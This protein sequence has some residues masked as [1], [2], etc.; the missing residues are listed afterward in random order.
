MYGNAILCSRECF[1]DHFWLEK[2]KAQEANPYEY[3]IMDGESYHFNRNKPIV[4]DNDFDFLGFGGHRF[5]I[6]YDNGDTYTTNNL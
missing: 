6:R 4:P 3:A 5:T 1:Y 2:C